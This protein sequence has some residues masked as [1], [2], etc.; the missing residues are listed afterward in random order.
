MKQVG[1]A[2]MRFRRFYHHAVPFGTGLVGQLWNRCKGPECSRYGPL[3]AE[4]LG[5]EYAPV[6]WPAAKQARPPRAGKGPG[7]GKPLR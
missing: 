2:T 7:G 3:R 4:E 5:F 1:Q 6:Q